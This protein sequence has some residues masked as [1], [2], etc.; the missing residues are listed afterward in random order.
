MNSEIGENTSIIPGSLG[1]SAGGNLLFK[2]LRIICIAGALSIPG[3]HSAIGSAQTPREPTVQTDSGF[4]VKEMQTGSAEIMELRRLSGMTWGQLAQLFE[5]TPRTL[6]FWASGKRLTA[7]NEERLRRIAE[8]V[9]QI[10]RGSA[11]E[12]RDALFTPQLDGIRPIDLI[13]MGKYGD[14]VS[15]LGETQFQR[16]VLAPLSSEAR[17]RRAP[18]KPSDLT[19][20]LQS[21]VHRDT[22]RTRIARAVRLRTKSH[23]DEA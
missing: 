9:R 4:T 5:V 13:H 16:P 7:S 10:D 20:A 15:R 17:S 8:T 6:H 11:R 2:S 22:G 18:M 3:T 23:G 19:N 1:T 12:N 21:N 14:A